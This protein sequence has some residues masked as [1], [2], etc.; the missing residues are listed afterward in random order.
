MSI[1]ASS[2]IFYLILL[3]A[4][5]ASISSCRKDTQPEP[6]PVN[7]YIRSGGVFILNEG[8]FRM[9]N[10]SI[11]YYHPDDST[12]RQ[13]IFGAA[14]ERPTGDVIQDMKL[15]NGEAWI[16]ANNSGRIEIAD[17]KNFTLLETITGPLSPRLLLQIDQEKAYVSDLYS[18]KVSILSVKNREVTGTVETGKSTEAMALAN[19]KVFALHWSA[20]GG[21]D[22]RSMTVID[23][24][25][26]TIVKTISLSKEPNSLAI[27]HR[28]KL[29]VLCSGGYLHEERPALYRIN[30]QSIEIELKIEFT[31][32]GDYP[33]RLC[34][35]ENGDTLYFL[36]RDVFRMRPEDTQ[37]PGQPFIQASGRL[38]YALGA[39][40]SG[41]Y[42][43]DA[44]DYQQ[45]GLIYVYDTEGNLRR[46]F[47][48]GIIP[49]GFVF[50]N[51]K[52]FIK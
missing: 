8:N 6:M 23:A 52:T 4:F 30:T 51:D 13:D 36:N 50:V 40:R 25:S 19:G 32:A 14:N 24:T 2:S 28:G 21:Y 17:A 5:L 46:S 12:L 20:L 48:A 39:G 18:S 43:S 3:V 16:V 7:D 42:I 1:R 9:A 10:G 34:T 44:L 15:I 38:F 49:G 33:V 41:I 31:G 29:W 22:N 11:T 26:D 35:S 47:T 45:N 37:L 27:D